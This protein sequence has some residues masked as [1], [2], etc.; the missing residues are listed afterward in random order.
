MVSNALFRKSI[1]GA[2]GS[3]PISAKSISV[4][5]GWH[6]P[7]RAQPEAGLPAREPPRP[8]PGG[9]GKPM[10]TS[11]AAAKKPAAKGAVEPPKGKAMPPKPSN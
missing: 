8:D 2:H 7:T 10:V 9:P 11:G 5:G 3:A 6:D 4:G 1:G